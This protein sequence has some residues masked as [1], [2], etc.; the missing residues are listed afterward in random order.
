MQEHPLYSLWMHLASSK[1]NQISQRQRMS[2][3][4]WRFY[5]RCNSN[6]T[7]SYVNFHC[8]LQFCAYFR[9][10]RAWKFTTNVD[11]H[12]KKCQFSNISNVRLAVVRLDV[13]F[14]SLFCLQTSL[15]CG[16]SLDY[17]SSGDT[18][19]NECKIRQK[20]KKNPMK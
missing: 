19:K 20:A 4:M 1:I 13:F 3:L 14:L 6:K 15:K 8:V 10:S 11:I 16:Q 5:V 12:L 18:K 9:R 2:L 17:L 7:G